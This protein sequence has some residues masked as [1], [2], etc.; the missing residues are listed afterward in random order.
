MPILP[1][2][3]GAVIGGAVVYL[4]KKNKKSKSK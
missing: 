4:L 2:A 1:F 3:V